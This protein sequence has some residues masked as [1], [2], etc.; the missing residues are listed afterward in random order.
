MSFMLIFNEKMDF[1][2]GQNLCS[3]IKI[4]FILE[5]SQ[6]A[7]H[8]IKIHIFSYVLIYFDPLYFI[9]I[10]SKPNIHLKENFPLMDV[11]FEPTNEYLVWKILI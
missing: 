7:I 6:D 4:N 9:S 10:F 3:I 2:H 5:L 1:L 11:N 8:I